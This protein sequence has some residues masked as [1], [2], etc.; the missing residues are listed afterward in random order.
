MKT[1]VKLLMLLTLGAV[2]CLPGVAVADIK[3]DFDDVRRH[4][5]MRQFLSQPT[6]ADSPGPHQVQMHTGGC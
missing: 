6:T 2:I 5:L 4:L 3:R 1:L